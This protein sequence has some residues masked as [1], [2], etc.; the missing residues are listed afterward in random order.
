MAVAVRVHNPG[1]RRMRRRRGN[2]SSLF[3]VNG[4]HMA[5]R[6]RRRV[7]NRRRTTHR[8]RRNP[9]VVVAGPRRRANYRRRRRVSNRRHHRVGRRHNPQ[10][11]S[12]LTLGLTAAVGAILTDVIQGFIPFSFG[13]PWG[14]VG[15]R[16]VTAYLLGWGAERFVSP[17]TA[18][19]LAAGGVVGAAQDAFRLAFGGLA[20]GAPTPTMIGPGQAALPGP[21]GVSDIIDQPAWSYGW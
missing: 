12:M 21:D 17:I 15:I 13:G 1:T 10:I 20:G 8:R 18:Q 5:R 2:P 9:V 14:K 3:L 16:V 11:R 7:T 4:G 6:R 19:A